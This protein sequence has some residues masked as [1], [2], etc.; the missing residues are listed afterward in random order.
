MNLVLV[1]ALPYTSGHMG[2]ARITRSM[3]ERFAARGHRVRVVALAGWQ[4]SALLDRP[5][6]VREEGGALLFTERGVEA[7]LVRDPD[8]FLSYLQREL[9]RDRADFVFLSCEEFRRPLLETLLEGQ[10][11]VIYMAH[12][13]LALP[14]GPHAAEPSAAKAEQLKRASVIT[15]SRYLQQYLRTH[16]GL[17]SEVLYPPCFG[18]RPFAP[19]RPRPDGFITLV[20]PGAYK[21]VSIFEG[22]ARAFAHLPFAAVSSW[23]TT[24]AD[25][26]R[27]SRLPNVTVLPQTDAMEEVYR[28]SRV[29]LVPSLWQEAF[30]MVTVEAMLR[31]IPVIASAAGGLP[32][33]KLGVAYVLPVREIS[34]YLPERP[35]GRGLP[36]VE[37][38]EQDLGPWC[39]ALAA[40]TEDA[41]HYRQLSRASY[42]A[43]TTFAADHGIERFERYLE[44]RHAN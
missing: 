15:C 11:P 26:D 43:A 14:F 10:A 21:G 16:G 19:P 5:V 44:T 2:A 17:E 18:E 25:R 40:L 24:R 29:L 32:E 34:R 4:L 38:P 1:Q 13:T 28:Q 31:G 42:A 6:P 3:A 39:A 23:S 7:H 37:V 30:G 9:G 35:D 41:D 22:L 20:N 8:A 33:A 36:G 27:L 12:T